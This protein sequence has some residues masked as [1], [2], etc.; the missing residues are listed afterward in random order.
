MFNQLRSST[1][2]ELFEKDPCY[3]N[4]HYDKCGQFPLRR[5]A[6]TCYHQRE[7]IICYR[8]LG[9]FRSKDEWDTKEDTGKLM[10]NTLYIC[11]MPKGTCWAEK[12]SNS[13]KIK[14]VALAVIELR[15]SEA[16]VCQLFSQSVS[17]NFP[18]NKLFLKFHSNLLKAFRVDLKVCL[19]LVL[20]NQYCLIVV[21][22]N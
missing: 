22:G 16:S 11:S 10:K 12:M 1:N 21:R 5:E 20:S 7:A 15:L 18:L 6:I 8:Q 14:P 13:K 19:G 9:T 4:S 3:Q 17:R 2:Q